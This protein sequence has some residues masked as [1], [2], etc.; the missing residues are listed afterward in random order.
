MTSE[1][2]LEVG[3]ITGAFGVRGWVKVWS[4]TDPI[5]NL[6]DYTP[7]QVK[8][9]GQ[10]QV[11]NVKDG[12]AQGRGLVA[13]LEGVNDRNQAELLMQAPI[14]ITRAQMDAFDDEDGYYWTDLE[15]CEV[16]AEDGS[17]FG[18]I[19]HLFD[20]GANQVMVVS[21]GKTERMIP[22]VIDDIVKA[23]DVPAKRIVVAWQADW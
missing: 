13:Q 7:W 3:K 11:L 19:S 2:L 15:G 14:F 17:S 22:W 18:T 6:L 9:G 23:V 12:H 20:N 21:D 1:N 5:E 10:W 8:V 16:V 4:Y